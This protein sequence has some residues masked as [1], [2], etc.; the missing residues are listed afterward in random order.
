ME[1]RFDGRALTGEISVN[2]LVRLLPDQS[3]NGDKDTP[4]DGQKLRVTGTG[5][6]Y[7]KSRTSIFT[8]RLIGQFIDRYINGRKKGTV[9]HISR[10]AD[11]STHYLTN[12]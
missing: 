10:T 9:G 8:Y 2:L 7:F 4:I 1:T 5:C 6:V 11:I 12:I 3:I